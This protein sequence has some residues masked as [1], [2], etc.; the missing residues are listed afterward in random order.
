MLISKPAIALVLALA[1]ALPISAK[2]LIVAKT[3]GQYTTIQNGLAAAVAG[4]TVLIKPGQY[5]EQVSFSK[6]GSKEAGYITLLGEAGAIVDGT[7][8]LKSPLVE[9]NNNSYVRVQGLE[10]QNVKGGGTPIGI[11]VNGGGSNIEIRKN[12]V[13][14]VE[15]TG[16]AHGI[17][18]YGDAT[19]PISRII[20]DGNEVN[21]CKLGQSESMVLNG[22][23]TDFEV[24]NNHVHDN[25]NIGIDFIGF[26]GTGP[27]ALDQARNGICVGNRV[28]NI[29]SLANVTYNGERSADGIYVD[30]GK[31][32][33][34]ERNTVDNADIG[35]EIASEH[36]GK[37][38][39]NI[40]VRNNFVSRSFQ[41]NIMMGGYASSKGN[42]GNIQVINNTTYA[43]ND[44]EV[45]LQFNCKG[46]TIKNNIFNAIKNNAYLVNSGSNN[47][48]VAADNNLYF[49]A[50]T[51]SAGAW[52]DAHAIYSNPSLVG[53]PGNLH[54]AANS[55]AIDKGAA[56]DS[57][58]GTLD[59]DGQA[60][61]FGS[62]V[63]LGADEVG[64]TILI[65]RINPFTKIIWIRQS[66]ERDLV[67]RRS[68]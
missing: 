42:A 40:M 55:L 4:D 7:G 48:E 35:I 34:I 14:N 43:G 27:A 18:I 50:S 41:G 22:N 54:L 64:G 62:K 52:Q 1:G 23:V 9:I 44:G 24:T 32:I 65:R 38:T 51:I 58:A 63:D 15:S 20:V 5:M 37:T 2:T 11:G 25:D 59:I 28:Y 8:I 19:A 16:N 45:V 6:S 12:H 53:A 67:G 3:E 36:G 26:E 21:N 57:L 17:G 60:R 29:S 39:S 56:L 66:K 33:F 47:T 61:I 49:G 13:H 10:V 30:G 68:S 31:D 46:V